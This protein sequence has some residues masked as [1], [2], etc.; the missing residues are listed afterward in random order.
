[1]RIPRAVGVHAENPHAALPYWYEMTR[2]MAVYTGDRF[3]LLA[4]LTRRL[5]HIAFRFVACI[6]GIAL[7]HVRPG[8][9]VA[10]DVERSPCRICC[11]LDVTV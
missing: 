10:R 1:M 8:L 4:F 7:M 2:R 9:P 6:F 11:A 3:F 5:T